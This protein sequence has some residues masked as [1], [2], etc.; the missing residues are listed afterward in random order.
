MAAIHAAGMV[1][2]YVLPGRVFGRFC[3]QLVVSGLAIAFPR[4]SIVEGVEPWAVDGAAKCALMG[5]GF[6]A[7]MVA[8]T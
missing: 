5:T 7:A 4:G 1:R 3:C 2:T 8:L 6:T